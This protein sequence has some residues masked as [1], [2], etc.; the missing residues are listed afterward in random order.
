MHLIVVHP[1]CCGFTDIVRSYP[2]PRRCV[3]LCFLTH[4]CCEV[5]CFTV[6]PH[7]C[8]R[9]LLQVHG[10]C[11][12]IPI[13]TT[14]PSFTFSHSQVLRGDM[15]H[16]CTASSFTLVAAGSRILYVSSSQVLRGY[17]FHRCTALSFTH[18]SASLYAHTH[19][20]AASGRRSPS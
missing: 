16:C 13:P 20:H 4:M 9:S 8:S 12:F 18:I 7:R 2:Y 19:T 5:I 1:H 11:T 10:Y 15:F 17:M 14:L 6:A 3:V